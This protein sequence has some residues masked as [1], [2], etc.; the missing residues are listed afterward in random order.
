MLHG[1]HHAHAEREDDAYRDRHVHVD[2][3]GF[4]RAPGRLE[5]R[6]AG[7]GR[8]GQH[9]QRRQP[10]EEITLFG[11]HVRDVAR[12]HRDRQ[13]HHVHGGKGRDA[14]TAQQEARLLGLDDLGAHRLERIGLVAELGEA[15][16]QRSRIDRA[17]AP[18]HREPAVGQ[19][20]TGARDGG[21]GGQPA[22]DLGHAAGAAHA[23]DREVDMIDPCVQLLDI[24]G[25]VARQ[26][27]GIYTV[28][29]R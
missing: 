6:L 11:Q 28:N 19:V 18:F 2:A 20:D 22:F 13:H 12:P 3:A 16:D 5:E 1:F 17:L 21:H 8:R 9:D 27:H 7:I 23:L 29:S 10:V 14:Q 4:Q 24:V 15:I 25:I 26:C